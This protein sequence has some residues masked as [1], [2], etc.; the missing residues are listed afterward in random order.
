MMIP[1]PEASI[2]ARY[3]PFGAHLDDPYSF[4]A[5][6]R[7]DEPVFYSPV[8]QAW[9]ITRYEDVRHVLMHPEVFSSA[10]AIRPVTASFNPNCVA[11]LKRGYPM[12]RGLIN[13]DGAA[14]ERLR[15][16][17][18]KALGKKRVRRLNPF[19]REQ[20][21]ALV[22][23][24]LPAENAELMH[25]FV[26]PLPFRVL[27]HL[28][29]IDEPD[30]EHVHEVGRAAS[31]IFRSGNLTP[32]EQVV[33]AR[34]MVDLHQTVVNYAR[35]RRT[36]PRDDLIT[37]IAAELAPGDAPLTFEQESDLAWCLPGVI[38]ST[39]SLEAILGTGIYYLLV[40]HDQWAALVA[41]PNLIES[42][43]EEICRYDPPAQTFARITTQPVTLNGVDLPKGTE[44]MVMFGSANRD[45]ALVDPPEEFDI[46]RPRMQHLTFGQGSHLC[47]GAPVVRAVLRTMLETFVRRMPGL[48]IV[49]G[50]PVPFTPSLNHRQPIRLP[51][52]W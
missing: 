21:D 52:T 24:M 41:R 17:F 30:Y 1:A 44:V 33:A 46:T 32:D 3:D 20:V 26:H 40:N 2:G 48:R 45:E 5:K 31:R 15:A 51:V 7:I 50:Q 18:L 38:G 16:P 37:A 25:Q 12:T 11:E 4:Y 6:A 43:I 14:H 36:D 19:I 47:L 28:L 42:A 22:D 8:F 49:D 39:N 13:T 23:A 35:A 27:A 29:G 9:V 10:N 34:K